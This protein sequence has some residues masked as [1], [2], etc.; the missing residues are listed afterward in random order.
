MKITH[1]EVGSKDF[2][3]VKPYRIANITIDKVS[4]CFVTLSLENGVTGFGT[5]APIDFVTGENMTSCLNALDQSHLSWLLNQSIYSLPALTKTLQ[6]K[7]GSSPAARAALDIALYDAY[8]KLCKIPLVDVLGR[9]HRTLPTSITVGIKNIDDSIRE[10]LEYVAQGFQIIKIKLGEDVDKDI[11]MVHVL[12]ERLP[13]EI[14]LRVDMNQGYGLEQLLKFVN[15][16]NELDIEL[17]EQPFARHANQDLQQLPLA[18]RNIIAADESLIS[19]DDGFGLIAPHKLCNIFNIKL[20]KCGGITPALQLA[21]LAQWAEV[22]LMWGCMD[23]S[24]IGISAAL[25]TALACPKTKYLDLDGSFDIAKDIVKG[26]FILEKGMLS[27]TDQPG[28][29]VELI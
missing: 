19:V 5:G 14:K 16:T 15:K 21:N 29:G 27:T 20:M 12:S 7:L 9:A 26:G 4:N 13:K 2:K 17:I 28:L 22:D 3:L 23:E 18:I 24:I 25:H 11:E 10:S 1:I 6:T 8:G